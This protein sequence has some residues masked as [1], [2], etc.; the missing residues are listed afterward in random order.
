MH[1]IVQIVEIDLDTCGR[2]FG[3]GA[4]GATLNP[5]NKSKCFNTFPTCSFK[6]AFQKQSRTL[7]F[8]EPSYAV[9]SGDY[10]PC[11]KSVGGYEQIVNIAGYAANIGSLGSRASVQV[12]L[13][14]FADRGVLTDKYWSERMSGAAQFG[15][16]GYDP[17]DAGT[18]FG[19]LKAQ[20]INYSGRPLR[21]IQAHYDDAG[22]LVNDKVRS[23][24]MAEWKGPDSNGSVTIVAKDILSLSD[25]EKALCPAPSR[26]R[27]LNDI[28]AVQTNAR[29]SP[30]GIGNA[31]YPSSGRATIGN[32]IVTFTRTGD[33]LTL[34]R[35]LQRTQATNHSANDAVQIAFHINRQRADVT[36]R[37]LLRD[38]A[39]I[40]ASWIDF[41]N[42]QAEFN[43]WGAGM[44]LSA[45]I[46]KPE[47]VSKLIGEINQLG[48]TIWWDEVAQLIKLKLNHPPEE[49]PKEWSDRN[50]IISIEQEDNDDERATRVSL[51]SVQID[52]TKGVSPDNFLR[53]YLNVFVD[54]ESP[55]FYNES[56]TH[57]I[58]TRWIN[59]G[60]DASAKIITGRL[61]NRYKIAPITYKVL[62]DAKDDPSLTDVISLDSYIAADETGR[63][64]KRLTQVFYRKDE[65]NGST[66]T[67]RLQRFQFDSQYGVITENNRPRYNQSTE[68][69]KDKGTYIVGPSLVFADG[70]PAY[71]IV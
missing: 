24:V 36:I 7:R 9:K 56:K 10:I 57:T 43:K 62:I 59:H 13:V 39:N 47:N 17:M 11:L 55:D 25:N 4:C 70:R 18:F 60:D 40:P 1:K 68:A 6:Q 49:P 12:N 37:N 52:P 5:A 28:D 32:E 30:S 31:E 64:F 16:A 29:L 22:Q 34:T 21:V 69:Q 20:N 2:T 65:R 50:N 66:V 35:G 41:A 33:N 42:W 8:I 48:I 45:T 19:K 15:G 14:D 46:C 67:A 38:Y 44:Y 53:N 3:V 26:G 61:L 51:W 71:Q 54:G 27:L 63:S 23:Y 58:L